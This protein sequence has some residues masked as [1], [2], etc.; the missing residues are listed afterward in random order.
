MAELID[1]FEVEEWPWGFELRYANPTGEGDGSLR[2]DTHYVFGDK[3]YACAQP[4]GRWNVS[5][6][7]LPEGIEPCDFLRSREPSEENVAALKSYLARVSAPAAAKM[8]DADYRA[9]FACRPFGGYIVRCSRL[10]HA[11]WLALVGDAAHAVN[12]ATG[13]GINS[14]LEDATLLGHALAASPGA[15]LSA[16]DGLRREDAHAL[17][18]IALAQKRKV[19][20]TPA[21]RGADVVVRILLGLEKK[22]GLIRGTATDFMAGAKAREGVKGYAELRALEVRQYKYKAGPAKA[23]MRLA[24]VPDEHRAVAKKGQAAAAPGQ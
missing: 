22:L 9:F 1:D 19:A 10:Q 24:G 20:G 13:E 18:E 8:C 21:E 4:D 12:P 7:L 17:A 2:A 15:P 5:L 14:S 23:L 3:G 16:F 11:E 6:S